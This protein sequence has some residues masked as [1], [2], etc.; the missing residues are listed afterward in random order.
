MNKVESGKFGYSNASELI[1]EAIRE[2]LR[3]LGFK[4]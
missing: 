2:R 3:E 4:I 1:K